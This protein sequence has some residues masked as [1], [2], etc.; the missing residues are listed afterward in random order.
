MDSAGRQIALMSTSGIILQNRHLHNEQ[1]NLAM[2]RVGPG[3]P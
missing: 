1:Q 3:G 2:A